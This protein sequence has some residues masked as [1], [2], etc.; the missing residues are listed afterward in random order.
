MNSLTGRNREPKSRFR[1][2]AS[3]LGCLIL[4]RN[5]VLSKHQ[6]RFEQVSARYLLPVRAVAPAW[7][8]VAGTSWSWRRCCNA[9]RVWL[10][11]SLTCGLWSRSF[12][13]PRKR[14]AVT[15]QLSA[16]L[17]PKF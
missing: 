10:T 4:Q 2:P 8:Q 3:K 17:M 14:A 15:S 7:M 11:M 12:F 9:P 16:A 6:E 1:P 5:A 13:N